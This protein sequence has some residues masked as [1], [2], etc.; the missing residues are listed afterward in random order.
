MT[1]FIQE[2]N[3]AAK[4]DLINSLETYYSGKNAEDITR[5]EIRAFR[6]LSQLVAK[7]GLNLV[8]GTNP[9]DALTVTSNPDD[10]VLSNGK[11]YPKT[12]LSLSQTL[13][14]YIDKNLGGKVLTLIAGNKESAVYVSMPDIAA[15]MACGGELQ[16][17]AQP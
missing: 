12:E 8:I 4:A 3:E 7:V 11:L 2:R 10:G 15:T 1:Y 9:C 6:L 17:V 13:P 16:F 14:R 5:A